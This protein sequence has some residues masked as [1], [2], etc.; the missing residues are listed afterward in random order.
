MIGFII[1]N[2]PAPIGCKVLCTLFPVDLYEQR[3]RN[4]LFVS[5]EVRGEEDFVTSP[6]RA[7]INTNLTT[8]FLGSYCGTQLVEDFL[9]ERIKQF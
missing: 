9:L 1:H 8:T 3:E 2:K 5:A 6:K 7:K 4:V